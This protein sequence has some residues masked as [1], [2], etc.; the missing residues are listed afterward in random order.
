MDLQIELEYKIEQ[1][2]KSVKDLKING[3]KYAEAER[4]YKILLDYKTPVGAYI[5][6]KLRAIAI[7]PCGIH[8]SY[9]RIFLSSSSFHPL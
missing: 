6:T 9:N 2:K 8:P 4:D 7:S 3:A 5:C 1:L